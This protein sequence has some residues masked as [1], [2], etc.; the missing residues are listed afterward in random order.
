MISTLRVLTNCI[1][2][3][4]PVAI[5]SEVWTSR[6]AYMIML[7]YFRRTCSSVYPATSSLSSIVPCAAK[8][9]SWNISLGSEIGSLMVN[10]YLRNISVFTPI[11]EWKLHNTIYKVM[12]PRPPRKATK[13]KKNELGNHYTNS[14]T[15]RLSTIVVAPL[16][17]CSTCTFN[18]STKWTTSPLSSV[19]RSSNDSA[20]NGFPLPNW[21]KKF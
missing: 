15:N 21:K 4:R 18:W 6:P 13:S 9:N 12:Q 19:C 17:A 5:V 20:S 14:R 7:T 16:P 3:S 8:R 2:E 11:I 1:I 10:D